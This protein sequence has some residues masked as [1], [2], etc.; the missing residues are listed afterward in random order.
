MA[1]IKK[2]FAGPVP[3]MTPAVGYWSREC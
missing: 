2:M 3:A 1:A